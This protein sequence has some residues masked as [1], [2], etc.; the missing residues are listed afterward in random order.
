MREDEKL[1]FILIVSAIVA[2]LF[3]HRWMEASPAMAQIT[4]VRSRPLRFKTAVCG[5]EALG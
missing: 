1:R 4:G 3:V 5:P 2:A